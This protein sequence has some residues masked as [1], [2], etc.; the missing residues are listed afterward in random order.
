MTHSDL[1]RA[2]L[3]GY[4]A[5]LSIENI[6]IPSALLFRSL[7]STFLRDVRLWTRRAKQVTNFYRYERLAIP[8]L[9][10]RPHPR[11]TAHKRTG[12]RPHIQSSQLLL[13]HG[14][15]SNSRTHRSNG[16]SMSTSAELMLDLSAP[17]VMQAH[18]GLSA[19][20]CRGKT[21]KLS[22]LVVTHAELCLGHSGVS[23]E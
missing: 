22:A 3:A 10:Q 6:G 15:E 9:L 19:K 1:L 13:A 23:I 11:A 16:L 5:L 20:R 8:T 21:L 17:E 18:Y 4:L 14:H 12:P 2:S 7:Y